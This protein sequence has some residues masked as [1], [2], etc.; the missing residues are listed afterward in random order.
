[1]SLGPK[2]EVT[3]KHAVRGDNITNKF[4]NKLNAYKGQNSFMN[5]MGREDQGQHLVQKEQDLLRHYQKIHDY[6]GSGQR[7]N[8]TMLNDYHCLIPLASCI[9]EKIEETQSDQN[10]LKEI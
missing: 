2:K 5:V 1:M 6:V 4:F 9:H 7:G 10:K 3:T 8:S